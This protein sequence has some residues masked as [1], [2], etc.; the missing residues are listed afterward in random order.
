MSR[1]TTA[2]VCLLY[3]SVALV[4]GVLHHHHAEGA[5]SPHKDCAA[6]AWQVNGVADAPV[7]LTPVV[8]SPFEMPVLGRNVVFISSFFYLPSASRAPPVASA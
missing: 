7:V 4:F 5:L 6:C 2:V 3:L 1:A 8:A